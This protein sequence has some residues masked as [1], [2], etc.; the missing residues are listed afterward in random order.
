MALPKNKRAGKWYVVDASG[1]TLGR[2]ASRIAMILMGKIHPEFTPNVAMGD[3]VV[4][5]N[6][7]L[8]RVKGTNKPQDKLYTYYTGYTRGIKQ[9]TL[10]DMLEHKPTEV[11]REAVRKMLPKNMLARKM[12]S[13]LKVYPG[14]DHC[15]TAQQ[16]E[17]LAL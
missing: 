3:H 13:K 5:L 10:E 17:P 1:K 12:L 6:A 16:P 7:K 9:T 15:H 2:L 4:V 14:A 11:I 8:I